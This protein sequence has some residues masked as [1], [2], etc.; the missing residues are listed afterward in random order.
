MLLL[1]EASETPY[2]LTWVGVLSVN[3]TI[4]QRVVVE[5]YMDSNDIT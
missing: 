1:P 4:S 3:L 5:Q 2:A